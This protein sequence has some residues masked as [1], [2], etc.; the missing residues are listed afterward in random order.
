M[1][2]IFAFRSTNPRNLYGELDPVGPDNDVTLLDVAARCDRVVI[3]WGGHGNLLGRGNEVL[4]ILPTSK[5]WCLSRNS[6]GT[7]T[8]PLYI[9]GNVSLIRA[10]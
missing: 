6:D 8:H 3:G 2:N 5:I 4:A 10:S 7:P 9:P 1:A